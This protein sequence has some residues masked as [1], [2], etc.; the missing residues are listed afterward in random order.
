[1]IDLTSSYTID[2]LRTRQ[3][4]WDILTLPD[5]TEKYMFNSRVTSSWKKGD[6]IEWKGEYNGCTSYQKGT[7]VEYKPFHSIMYTTFDPNYGLADRIENYLFIVYTIQEQEKVKKVT[8]SA[9]SYDGDQERIFHIDKGWKG[10]VEKL[11]N[12]L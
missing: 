10:M 6:I 3:E 7:I 9:T 11:R 12:F 5:W 1:M 4:I 2:S 8:L